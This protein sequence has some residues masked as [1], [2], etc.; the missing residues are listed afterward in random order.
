ML[1]QQSS[2]EILVMLQDTS[3]LECDKALDKVGF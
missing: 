1:Y 3:G 2:F